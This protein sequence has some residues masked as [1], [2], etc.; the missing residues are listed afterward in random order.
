MRRKGRPHRLSA[1]ERA[2]RR[3]SG[4]C[5]GGF[6]LGRACRRFLELQFELVEQL[7]AAL[8]GLRS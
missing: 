3:A 6:V 7:A 5:R 2:Y 1:G 4:R 8:G